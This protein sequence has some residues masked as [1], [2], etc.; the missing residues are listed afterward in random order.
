MSTATVVSDPGRLGSLEDGWRRLAE[1]AG[2]PYLTPEW[3]AA[4]RSRPG[5]RPVV[6]AV[7]SE[8]GT[9]RGVLPLVRDGSGPVRW[10]R[11][12]GDDLGDDYAMLVAPGDDPAEVARLAG[13]GLRAAGVRWD[14]FALYYVDRSAPWLAGLLEG[15]GG[16]ATMR[17]GEA[18]RPFVDLS[19]GD[20]ARYLATLKR[21]DR[22]ETRRLE[23]RALEAGA[24]YRLLEDPAQVEEG[25]AVLFRLHDMRWSQRGGSSLASDESRRVL[26]GFAAA[27][28]ER[29]WV[30]LWLLEIEGDPVAAE[31]AWR[32]GGRQ[33]HYQAGFDPA[34][35]RLGVGIVLFA[36]ALE[37]AMG[38]G[39]GEADLGWG[40]SDYKRRYAQQARIA[41]RLVALP[42][43]HPLRPALAAAL[44][45]RREL[46]SRLSPE[47]RA[48][49]SR[50]LRRR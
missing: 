10:L 31:L 11:F 16:P 34:R 21:T 42:R 15:L 18:V 1:L 19:G 26:S 44:R 39:V 17:R 50:L 40:E 35:G 20:W 41:A 45:G 37:D 49:V 36:H 25:M 48:Q 24:S 13:R 5:A 23:R 43:R 29:G 22:K 46:A 47:R 30:R 14:A 3:H 33:R 38:A 2:N 32:I 27:A 9:L 8:D 6:V 7:R 28:A 12:P 4:C